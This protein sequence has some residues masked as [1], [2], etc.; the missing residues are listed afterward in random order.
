[1]DK[2]KFNDKKEWRKFSF[3]LSGIL[4]VIALIQ[5]LLGKKLSLYFFGASVFIL[6]VGIAVPVLIKPIFIIFSYIGF[7][8]NWFMTRLI[9]TILFYL[10][11]TPT[12]FIAK[13]FGREFLSLKFDRTPETYWVSKEKRASKNYEKMF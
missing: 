3:G 5:F 11:F 13:L 12:R 7:V 8:L 10:V 4:F 2:S 9:L 6:F 1:M